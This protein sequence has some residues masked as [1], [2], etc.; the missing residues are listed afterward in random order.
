M[1]QAL[2]EERPLAAT[3]LREEPGA[4]LADGADVVPVHRQPLEPVRCDDVRDALD[5]RVRRARRELREAVVLADEDRGQP[6]EG[7]EVDRLDEDP[8]LDG[9]VAEEH[10]GYPIASGQ[11]GGEGASK[12]ERDVA[13]DDAGRAEEAA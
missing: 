11:P 3:R 1:S 8:A 7:R 12:R 5:R 9:A 4:G 10:N 2:E 6:P 13:A